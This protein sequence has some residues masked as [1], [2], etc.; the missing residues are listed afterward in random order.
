MGSRLSIYLAKRGY[1][2]TAERII[3]LRHAKGVT[4]RSI[5]LALSDRGRKGLEEEGRAM[6][7]KII[8]YWDGMK[9]VPKIEIIFPSPSS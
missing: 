3:D 4:G 2:V 5:N 9:Q 6:V 8:G 7:L 1:K